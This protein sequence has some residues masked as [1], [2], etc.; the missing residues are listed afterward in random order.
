MNNTNFSFNNDAIA[1]IAIGYC[2][3]TLGKIDLAKLPFVLPFI[4]HDPCLR[5]LKNTSNKRSL[6]EFIVKN[7]EVLMGF[8]SRYFNFLPLLI[9]SI[10]LLTE[11]KIIR[12]E[13]D[14]IFFN[15]QSYFDPTDNVLIGKRAKNF[16]K[17][18]DHLN[19]IMQSE[20]TASFY[21]KLKITL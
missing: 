13:K 8:N 14:V 21:L 6:E 2:I 20:S 12:V 19:Q 3:M 7:P 5:K 11:A 4:L 1:T 15:R 10:T 9:N 17:G 16:F 18:I